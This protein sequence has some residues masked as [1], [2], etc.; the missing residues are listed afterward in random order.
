VARG[1]LSREFASA[2]AIWSIWTNRGAQIGEQDNHFAERGPNS[3]LSATS[4]VCYSLLGHS[5]CRRFKN[6]VFEAEEELMEQSTSFERNGNKSAAP[7]AARSA[8]FVDAASEQAAPSALHSFKKRG[9]GPLLWGMGGTIMSALGFIG[10]ALFEQ[11]N[12]MLTELRNDLK[13]FNEISS[14]LVKK[15]SL[16]R[17]RD[18]IKERFK[19]FEESN[20]AKA[21]LETELRTSER[22]REEMARELQRM[23]ER[24]AFLEGRQTASPNPQISSPRD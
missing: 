5:T 19:Q 2:L 10:L 16:Q 20:T 15:E 6:D 7:A 4:A 12:G 21:Q 23:R 8:D 17:L 18:Q 14:E 13:H 9:R 11:Y 22:A 3:V 24:L 1:L